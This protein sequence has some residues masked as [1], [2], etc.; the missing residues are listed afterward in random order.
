[1]S[2]ITSLLYSGPL[3]WLEFEIEELE[4][5]G[6]VHHYRHPVDGDDVVSFLCN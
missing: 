3:D 5:G 1:V 6:E 4:G 2:S